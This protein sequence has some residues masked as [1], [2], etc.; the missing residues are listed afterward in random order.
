MAHS[1]GGDK[2]HRQGVIPPPVFTGDLE[3]DR[4]PCIVPHSTW[5][6]VNPRNDELLDESVRNRKSN[7]VRIWCSKREPFRVLL[8]LLRHVVPLNDG[9]CRLT[10]H[11]DKGRRARNALP[12]PWIWACLNP[13]KISTTIKHIQ[14]IWKYNWKLHYSLWIQWLLEF[15]INAASNW[16]WCYDD[17]RSPSL[18]TRLLDTR[19]M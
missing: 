2:C 14:W 5:Y 15:P 3:Y 7:P 19:L 16:H 12:T 10:M 18:H 11:V 17:T 9:N 8:P 6:V 4:L 13:L 1:S